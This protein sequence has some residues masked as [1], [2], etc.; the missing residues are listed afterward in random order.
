MDTQADK[1]KM[2]KR[3]ST[4]SSYTCIVTF[5]YNGME[6]FND[7]YGAGQEVDR[8][9]LVKPFDPNGAIYVETHRAEG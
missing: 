2:W 9:L 5:N 7:L 6:M 8:Y 4:I 1:N 3:L